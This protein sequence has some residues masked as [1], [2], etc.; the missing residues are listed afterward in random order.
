MCAFTLRRWLQADAVW[1]GFACAQC[2]CCSRWSRRR[3][4]R[5]RLALTFPVFYDIDFS[6]DTVG[7][8]PATSQWFEEFPRAHPS[9]AIGN[10]TVVEAA[11]PLGDQPLHFTVGPNPPG[12]H[13][14]TNQIYLDLD[15]FRHYTNYFEILFEA[16]VLS[17]GP[18]VLPYNVASSFSVILDAPSVRRVDFNYDGTITKYVSVPSPVLTTIGS[19]TMGQKLDVAIGVNLVDD[20]WSIAIGGTTLHVGD[21]GL[22]SSLNPVRFGLATAT[23]SGE[24]AIDNIRV[25]TVPEPAAGA[26][27]VLG[28]TILGA[29]SPRRHAARG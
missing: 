23:I 14:Q 22:S 9:N 7:A 27:L 4:W 13:L 29:R 11:G 3:F 2:C 15:Y 17:L 12:E 18:I 19:Y 28:L 21:F 10:L 1:K 6:S 26:L 5:R 8:P 16:T 24:A 25:V 20:L